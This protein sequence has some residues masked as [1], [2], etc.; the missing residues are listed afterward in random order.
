MR[1]SDPIF[2]TP[3][4]FPRLIEVMRRLRDPN[5][6][7]PWDIEQDFASIAPYTIEEAYEVADAIQRE[8]WGE[9]EGE[10][11][12]LLLQVIY[13][14]QMGSEAGY[15]DTDSIARRIT[16]KMIDRHPHVFGAETGKKSAEQQTRD[17]EAAKAR[18]RAA[19]GEKSTLD[20][21]AL[22]LPALLRALKLQKR[23][24]RVGFDWDDAELVLDKMNEEIGELKEAREISEDATEAEFGD[25]MFVLVNLARHWNIDPE[26]ALRRTNA[27]VERRFA[28]IEDRLA[29]TGKTPDDATLEE[30]DALWN[31][32][33]ADERS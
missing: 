7:C 19:R 29:T 23:L 30:L 31:A 6:G 8:A 27:K 16:A 33:K 22:G 5:G 21:V 13:H 2:E 25:L 26:A 14:G 15:F 1:Q 17:W 11:G 4:G 9:L 24:A 18:E 3:E 28:A 12:D 20:G 32:V 10:L